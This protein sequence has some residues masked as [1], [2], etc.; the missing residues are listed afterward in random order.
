MKRQR[1]KKYDRCRISC[2]YG[3]RATHVARASWLN[4]FNNNSQFNANDRNINNHNRVRGIAQTAETPSSMAAYRDLW[5]ELCSY[6]NLELAYKKARKGKTLKPY[7]IEFEKNLKENLQQLRTE[8]FLHCYKPKPLQTFILREPKTR[9]ISKSHFRDRVIHHALCNVI[10]PLFENSFIYD[11]Y[12]NRKT[13]GTLKAIQRFEFYARKISRNY[14]KS[15]FVLKADVRKYFDHV[16]HH[17]LL[18]ILKRKIKDHKIMWLVKTILSNYF[19]A[20][21]KGMPL[22]NLTSQFFANIYLNELDQF[23]KK[24]LR[25]TYYIR[26][27]DDFVILNSSENTLQNYKEKIDQFLSE[28]L[29]LTLHPDKSKVIPSKQGIEFLGLKVFPH[30]KTIKKKNLRKFK[31]KLSMLSSEY[32]QDKASYD[33]IYDFMEGWNAYIQYAD[34]FNLRFRILAGFE[35]EFSHEISTK[36]ISRARKFIRS[37][38]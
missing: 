30:H 14:T 26:Y 27:V 18:T 34:A 5:K 12:A 9:K 2:V 11:S 15:A 23:V 10:E 16:D 3:I 25:A 13:K 8:L 33:Q 21:G 24:Q 38:Q 1:S 7:I 4:N 22:G 29:L 17:V 6:S 19:T 35:K 37:P 31:R 20:P 36:E 28:N 32:I